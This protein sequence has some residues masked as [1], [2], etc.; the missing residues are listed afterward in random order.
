MNEL[1]KAREAACE[2]SSGRRPD[3]SASLSLTIP[4]NSPLAQKA[5]EPWLSKALPSTHL[6]FCF[7]VPQTQ[8]LHLAADRR[9][10]P[11]RCR[12]RC[13]LVHCRPAAG[14][15]FN[16]LAGLARKEDGS[17][18]ACRCGCRVP[19]KAQTTSVQVGKA[20][21]I[22]AV[23]SFSM[24]LKICSSSAL[25]CPLVRDW[26]SRNDKDLLFV[27]V[28][29]DQVSFAR[30]SRRR[31]WSQP[32]NI[33]ARHCKAAK[34]VEVL[35]QLS[36]L[37]LLQ[38]GGPVA[39]RAR[40]VCRISMYNSL[41]AP[42]GA[43]RRMTLQLAD[44]ASQLY[45]KTSCQRAV[46]RSFRSSSDQN[47][48]FPTARGASGATITG[49]T[50]HIRLPNRHPNLHPSPSLRP[51]PTHPTRPI[52]PNP[53]PRR[54]HPTS[55]PIRLSCL[56]GAI[57]SWGYRDRRTSGP[58]VRAAANSGKQ[59][60]SEPQTFSRQ[61]LA[62]AVQPEPLCRLCRPGLL[63]LQMP[64]LRRVLKSSVGRVQL[65]YTA[66]NFTCRL[67]LLSLLRAALRAALPNSCRHLCKTR[68]QNRGSM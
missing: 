58:K 15:S 27:L 22:A 18:R 39:E 17:L 61:L 14:T 3:N 67:P 62:A 44:G 10:C 48:S 60:F 40:R 20:A 28:A 7:R 55:L 4:R 23:H 11:R 50:I 49:I 21:W 37:F 66:G 19:S 25:S 13:L 59:R 64:D 35:H 9:P 5:K 38:F 26:T 45:L 30:T 2:I 51:H 46:Y 12:P 6:G 41:L 63:V 68:E 24:G 57:G 31:S 33:D 43:E 54:R 29:E 1:W 52:H 32:N 16:R 47:S 36:S 53:R 34:Q 65:R 42:S 8:H 56:H